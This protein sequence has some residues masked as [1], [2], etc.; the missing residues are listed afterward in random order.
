MTEKWAT[1]CA[2][3]EQ[4]GAAEYLK[5]TLEYERR[6][7]TKTGAEI[8]EAVTAAG[9]PIHKA[10]VN[11]RLAALLVAR[12]TRARA[13]SKEFLAAFAEAYADV[14][15]RGSG[16]TQVPPEERR[17]VYLE[18]VVGEFDRLFQDPSGLDDEERSM[19]E[20]LRDRCDAALAGRTWVEYIGPVAV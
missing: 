20:Q 6:S 8:A 17:R 11:R 15:A 7:A 3:Y 10:T 9:F 5:A 12:R 1:D 4:G 2:G 16:G 13:N 19:I 14:N 18:G